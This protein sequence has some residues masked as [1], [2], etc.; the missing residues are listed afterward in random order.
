M[1]NIF[2]H[3]LLESFMLYGTNINIYQNIFWYFL[4]IS[5]DSLT[6]KEPLILNPKISRTKSLDELQCAAIMHL[7]LKTHLEKE[8]VHQMR[9]PGQNIITHKELLVT[10]GLDSRLQETQ[11]F[12]WI[13]FFVG[14]EMGPHVLSRE[15]INIHCH[16]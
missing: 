7:A 14:R 6:S 13:F 1:F 9:H 15:Y 8:K 3:R 11:G 2:K 12:P 4:I 5:S 16:I 10:E